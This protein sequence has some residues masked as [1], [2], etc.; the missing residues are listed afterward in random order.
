MVFCKFEEI[1][2]LMGSMAI[3]NE[4]D[5]FTGCIPCFCLGDK[6]FLEPLEAVKVTCPSIIRKS[7]ASGQV[8]EL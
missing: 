1:I 6:A 8:G 3:I 7:N 4:E 5:W 2:L